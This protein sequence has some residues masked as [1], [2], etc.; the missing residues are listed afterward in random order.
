MSAR[1][2]HKEPG[3]G[4]VSLRKEPG[5]MDVRGQGHSSPEAE[6]TRLPHKGARPILDFE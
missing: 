1:Y 4:R 2:G 6:P 3:Q 5:V